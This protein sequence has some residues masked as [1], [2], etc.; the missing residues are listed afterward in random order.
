MDAFEILV[1]VIITIIWIVVQNSRR[2]KLKQQ[3]EAKKAYREQAEQNGPRRDQP[4]SRSVID[5]ILE[6]IRQERETE[7]VETYSPPPVQSSP[8][9]VI[10]G[11]STLEEKTAEYDKMLADIE[12]RKR[13]QDSSRFDAYKTKEDKWATKDEEEEENEY[14]SLIF[15][16]PDSPRKAIILSEILNRRHF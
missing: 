2:K 5:E 11:E 16:D 3:Q 6:E 9:P 4:S 13:N 15:E 1:Y 7:D 10:R 12:R 8:E 14:A